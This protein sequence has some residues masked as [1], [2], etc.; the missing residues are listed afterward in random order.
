MLHLG[1]HGLWT[2][3]PVE[4]RVITE[5]GVRDVLPFGLLT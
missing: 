5:G 1:A 2:K 4:R 3:T